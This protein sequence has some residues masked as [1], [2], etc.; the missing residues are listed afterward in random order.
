MKLDGVNKLPFYSAGAPHSVLGPAAPEEEHLRSAE[1]VAEHL[2]VNYSI[3]TALWQEP[4][5]FPR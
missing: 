3:A 4:H 1:S 5:V 2:E